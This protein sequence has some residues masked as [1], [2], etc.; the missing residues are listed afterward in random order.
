MRRLRASKS[1]IS[2]PSNQLT[3]VWAREIQG[4]CPDWVR[5]RLAG[6]AA[7]NRVRFEQRTALYRDLAARFQ[8]AGIEHLVLKGFTQWPYF[9][10]D[11][12]L[13]VD[14]SLNGDRFQA[15][16]GYVAPAW[17]DLVRHMR[18]FH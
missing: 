12:S 5:Q 16:T 14:R 13:Q 18:D 11:P 4:E 6:N 17:P 3:L 1:L 8:Q 2:A 15:S 10:P 9:T 7:D